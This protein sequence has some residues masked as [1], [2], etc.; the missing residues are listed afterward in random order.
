MD[1]ILTLLAGGNRPGDESGDFNK[2]I[3]EPKKYYFPMLSV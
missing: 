3:Q 2:F 1:S